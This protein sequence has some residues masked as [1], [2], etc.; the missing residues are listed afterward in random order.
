M[1]QET[2]NGSQGNT[3]ASGV[4]KNA[5][6]L[7]VLICAAL[8]VIFMNSGFFAFFFLAPLGYAAIVYNSYWFAFFVAAATNIVFSFV[9]RSFQSG[10][11]GLLLNV[12]YLAVL[13]LCFFWIMY[14]QRQLPGHG[15]K[16]IIRT[17]YR[18]I[19]SSAATAVIILFFIV[20]SSA[21]SV[22]YSTIF[23]QAEIL[24]SFS[25]GVTPETLVE[26]LKSIALRGGAIASVF[27]L[28]FINQY[29]AFTAARLLGKQK[30]QKPL[31]AFFVPENTIWFFSGAI[32]MVLITRQLRMEIPEIMAWNVL[33]VCAILFLTQGAGIALFFLAKKSSAFRLGVNIL[34]IFLIF[35]PLG[36][37]VIA[38][39]LTL[40]IAENW[41]PMRKRRIETASTPEP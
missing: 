26:L 3:D 21:D 39:L 38:A 2:E 19:I 34:I 1:F 30:P 28:F 6:L 25:A 40:G 11:G 4:V 31:S 8:S 41:V 13:A 37:I 23:A 22:Y 32:A 14:P 29:A 27:F 36:T 5:P 15:K 16:F 12:L 35:S 33:V 7:P 20:G 24:S 18:F 10:A 9:M 17:V